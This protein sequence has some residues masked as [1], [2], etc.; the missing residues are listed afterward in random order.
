MQT[1]PQIHTHLDTYTHA[2]TQ[3]N[4]AHTYITHMHT[5]TAVRSNPAALKI[6]VVFMRP[7]LIHTST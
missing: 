6:G 2:R 4:A 1:R 5:H 3:T 7:D